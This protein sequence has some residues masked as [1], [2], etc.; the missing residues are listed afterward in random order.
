MMM[1]CTLCD[2]ACQWLSAGWWFSSGTPVSFTNKTDNHEIKEI[3]KKCISK[4]SR[5]LN[6]HTN[7]F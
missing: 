5:I 7:F 3:F 4:I 1:R 2:K 6:V